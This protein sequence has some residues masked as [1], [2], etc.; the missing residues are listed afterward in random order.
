M[1]WFTGTFTGKPVILMGKSLVS[2]VDVPKPIHRYPQIS[3]DIHRYPQDVCR[4]RPQT[5]PQRWN[6]AA[7]EIKAHDG[8]TELQ[9]FQFIGPGNGMLGVGELIPPP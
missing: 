7:A 6:A 8:T 5:T 9:L 3:T 1:D 2:G 4:Q